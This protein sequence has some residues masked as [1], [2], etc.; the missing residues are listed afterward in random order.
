MGFSRR[1]NAKVSLL[2]CCKKDTDFSFLTNH[3]TG[4]ILEAKQGNFEIIRLSVSG[5]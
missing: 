4:R 3:E 2:G 5:G 1:D